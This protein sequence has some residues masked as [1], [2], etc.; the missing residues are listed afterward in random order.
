MTG[1]KDP[2]VIVLGIAQDGGVPQAGCRKHLACRD[3]T[4]R[5][6][7]V[8]IG[9]VDPATSERWLIECTP[10]FR[11]QLQKLDESVPVERVPGLNGIF[12]THSHMGH[13][14]GL[15]HLGFESMNVLGVPVYVMPRMQ[16]FLK[17]NG[18]W[19]QLVENH[20]IA[21]NPLREGEP[22]R[23]NF[24]LTIEPL[25]VPHRNEY[26]EVVGYRIDGPNRSVLF[27]PDIDRWEDWGEGIE[28]TISQ[29]DSSYLDGTFYSPGEI[30][31]RDMSTFPH[32]CI[33]ESMKRFEKLSPQDRNKI[34][35]IHLNHSNPALQSNSVARMTIEKNGYR[36]ACEMEKVDL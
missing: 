17:T 10:D 12:L 30:S 27:I 18:P 36:V 9:I 6:H 8:C 33:E 2:Y 32:P 26:S 13:Y 11:E 15:I 20:H 31:D 5:R 16:E 22:V 19:N 7:V 34:R 28:N 14:T 3:R 23:I 1:D 29:V 35:F 24:H 4:F 25:L 21:L